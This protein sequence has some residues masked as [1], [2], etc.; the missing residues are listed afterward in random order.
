M[1]DVNDEDDFCYTDFSD[2]YGEWYGIGE[3]EVQ[4]ILTH[5]QYEANCYKVIRKKESK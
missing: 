5:E 4:S 1:S 2:E 3:D